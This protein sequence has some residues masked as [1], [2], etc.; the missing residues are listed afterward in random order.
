MKDVCTIIKKIVME[1]LPEQKLEDI[2]VT[3]S[4]I[5]IGMNSSGFMKIVIGIES[6]FDFVFEDEDLLMENFTTV[7]ALKNYVESRI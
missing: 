7:E 1:S 2:N 3:D 6:E 5:E 4:L